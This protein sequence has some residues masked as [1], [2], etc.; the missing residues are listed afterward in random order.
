MKMTVSIL[1]FLLPAT[2]MFAAEKIDLAKGRE[3]W[4]FQP[5]KKP[6]L[7]SVKNKTWVKTPIDQ[8]ILARL[9]KVGLQP[10]PAA[11][12]LDLRRRIHYALTGLPTA[13]NPKFVNLNS[14]IKNQ[15][16]L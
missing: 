15:N 10:A 14:E 6:A 13:S 9:E 3:H 8:F 12:A 2:A 4:A 1:V 11:E 16:F 5:V 7:P